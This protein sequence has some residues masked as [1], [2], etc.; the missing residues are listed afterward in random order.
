MI[1]NSA[2]ILIEFQK[3]W[4]DQDEKLHSLM[5]DREQFQ[6]AIASAKT[7]LETARQCE[8]KI[9]HCGLGFQ[10]GYP[11][12]G[13]AQHGL[14]AAIARNGTFSSNEKG[15][16]FADPFVPQAGEFVVQGRTGSSGFAG[17]NLDS[18]LRNQGINQLYLT[19]FALHVCIESTL[20]Q[21]HDLGYAVAV[22]EDACAAF[23]QHQQQHVLE[24]VVHHF[25]ERITSDEVIQQLTISSNNLVAVY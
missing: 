13:K 21:G 8:I 20:R 16:Q 22:V 4:L 10:A 25:G 1:K 12:L 19:G 11:E 7:V 14:R 15:S 9:V 23:N 2:L 18:Y 5:Q 24:N 3:E 17:S 6:T